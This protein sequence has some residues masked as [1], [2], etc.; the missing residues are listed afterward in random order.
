MAS[1]ENRNGNPDKE[2]EDLP[3]YYQAARFQD[4]QH[5]GEVYFRAQKALHGTKHELSAYRFQLVQ[6]WFVAVLGNTPPDQFAQ[7]IASLLS[8]GEPTSLPTG[9]LTYL[10]QRRIQANQIGSWVE[11]HYRPG[12]HDGG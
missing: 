3:E 11:G 10:N 6:D 1:P 2:H 12:K 8:S 5:S 9:V 7:L 4:E